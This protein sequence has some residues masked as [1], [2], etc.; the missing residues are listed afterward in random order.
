[1]RAS[2]SNLFTTPTRTGI[3]VNTKRTTITAEELYVLVS[4]EFKRRQ[5]RDCD[6]CYI[7]LPY[8]VDRQD[9]E[10]SNWELVVPPD[11]GSGCRELVEELAMEFSLLFDLR[12]DENHTTH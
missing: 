10:T 7:Q 4:R 9:P 5:P 6:V 3:E 8:R 11:C 1:L 12:G 2:R